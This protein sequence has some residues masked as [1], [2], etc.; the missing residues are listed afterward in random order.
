MQV[1]EIVEVLEQLNVQVL[2]IV[3]VLQEVLV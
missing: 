2:K 3:V 1:L